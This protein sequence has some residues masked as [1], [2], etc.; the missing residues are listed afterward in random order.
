M[1]TV[2]P[3]HTPKSENLATLIFVLRADKILLSQHL[4]ELYGVSVSALNQV[5]KPQHRTLP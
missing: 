5:G 2:T 3:K 1:P 4:A